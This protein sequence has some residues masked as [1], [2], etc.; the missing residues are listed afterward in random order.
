MTGFF[1][2]DTASRPDPV[3][4]QPPIQCAPGVLSLGIKHREGEAEQLP[5]S[6]AEVKNAWSYTATS[7]IHLHAVMFSQAQDTSSGVVQLS[8]GT[9]LHVPYIKNIKHVCIYT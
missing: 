5:L 1:F 4:I 8:T 9:N 2:F 7:P 3:L 6:S